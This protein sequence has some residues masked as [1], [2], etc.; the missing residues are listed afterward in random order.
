[1]EALMRVIVTGGAGYIG[2]H[3]VRALVAAGHVVTVIDDLSNGHADMVKD[4]EL[5]RGDVTTPGLLR[6]LAASIDAQAI[7]HFAARIEVGA[8]VARP[9]LYY[10]TNVGGM[11]AVAGVAQARKIP[12]VFSSTAAVYGEPERSPIPVDH[13]C[14]PANPYGASKWLGERILADCA[15]AGG[16]GHAVLRYF[17]AAG[18]DVA[19]GLSER[20]APETHLVPLAIDAARRGDPPLRMFGDD[21]PTEDG[22]CVRDYVHVIDLADAHVRALDAI[23]AAPRGITVNLGGGQGTTVRQV[24]AAVGEAVGKPV[25]VVIAPRRAGDVAR[26]VAD[27]G[28]AHRLLGW[29]PTRSSIRQIIADAVASRA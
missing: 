20:H 26:L 11:I 5:V 9:D 4:A 14:R 8:S 15:A 3:V 29:I 25:P 27:V 18:A 10:A 17:N 13:P 21:W 16:F 23:V 22:T 28:E 1:L 12:V 24:L 19:A 6:E 7:L 2:S